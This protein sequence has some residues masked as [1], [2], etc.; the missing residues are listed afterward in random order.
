MRNNTEM[1]CIQGY[2]FVN[3]EGQKV[4]AFR[5]NQ[6]YTVTDSPLRISN[7][8]YGEFG[9]RV[10]MTN[11]ELK[12]FFVT[13]K[14]A[15]QLASIER[16]LNLV[17]DNADHNLDNEDAGEVYKL[18]TAPAIVHLLSDLRLHLRKN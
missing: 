17:A 18:T 7:V 1:V 9:T 13:K 8:V 2:S 6:T 4:K 12:Q 16:V 15:K 10:I 3:H 5:K 11:D 14:V